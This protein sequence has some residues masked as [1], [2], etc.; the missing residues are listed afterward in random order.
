MEN[1]NGNMYAG[2]IHCDVMP[3]YLC[4]HTTTTYSEVYMSMPNA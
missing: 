2:H 3:T 4:Y 1:K